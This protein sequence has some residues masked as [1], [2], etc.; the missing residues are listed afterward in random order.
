MHEKY[1]TKRA[2]PRSPLAGTAPAHQPLGS[3]NATESSDPTQHAKG[4]AVTPTTS[5]PP[6]TAGAALPSEYDSTALGLCTASEIWQ[7]CRPSGGG[8]TAFEPKEFFGP[9]KEGLGG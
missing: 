6:P 9:M 8:S 2:G 5:G 7:H 4:R 3:A 1:G